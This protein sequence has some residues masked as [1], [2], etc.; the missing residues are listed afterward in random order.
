[1]LLVA[2]EAINVF[3]QFAKQICIEQLCR[4]F[5]Y[6]LQ[7]FIDVAKFC[8][9]EDQVSYMSCKEESFLLVHT[10]TKTRP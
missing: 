7:N 2:F 5:K 3:L 6:N 4:Y 1:M 8:L 10:N 9:I